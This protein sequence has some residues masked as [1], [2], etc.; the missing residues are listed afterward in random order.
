[1]SA[2]NGLCLY[3]H[4]DY[5]RGSYTAGSDFRVCEHLTFN[6]S[7]AAATGRAMVIDPTLAVRTPVEH[8][9]RSLPMF[10]VQ[11]ALKGVRRLTA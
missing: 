3:R 6:R 10:W 7:I 2:F 1:M 5:S 4:E 9:R 8:G 11:R